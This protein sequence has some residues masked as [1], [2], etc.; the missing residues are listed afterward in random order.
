MV[1]LRGS[2]DNENPQEVN[3]ERRH[4]L[5][6]EV[7]FSK[8]DAGLK[9]IPEFN[10]KNWEDF[11]R[12]LETQFTI[13]GLDTFLEYEPSEDSNIQIRNDKLASAQIC[14]RL[15]H[16]QYKQVASCRTTTQIW[17]RLQEIYDESAE[18]KAS[19]IF[20]QFIHIQKKPTQSM[21][22]YLDKVVE[23][24]HDLRTYDI[25]L[26]E[27]AVCVKALDGLPET[28]K[29]I[30][31][32]A[33]ASQVTTIPR[34]TNLLLSSE[35]D[36]R[37]P[38]T[39]QVN[40]REQEMSNEIKS[41][42]TE[43]KKFKKKTF[44]E[45]CKRTNHSVDQCWI[46]HPELKK[47][48][49]RG[50]AHHNEETK[51]EEF[52][53]FHT[54]SNRQRCENQMIVDSGAN[55]SMTKDKEILTDYKRF[56]IPSKVTASNGENL[57]V[58]GKGTLVLSTIPPIKIRDVLHVPDLMKTLISTN[59]ITD[60]GYKIIIKKDL[61]ILSESDKI[62]LTARNLNGLYYLTP[63]A[64]G[65]S[66]T[67]KS[68]VNL[69][70]A[71]KRFGHA[72]DERLKKL[73]DN[74][75]GIELEMTERRAC[76]GC[77]IGQARR[78]PF[79]E[80]RRTKP[81]RPFEIVSSDIK[82]PL[83][84]TSEGY[85]YYI[86]YNC[87]YSKWCWVTFL[88][89]KSPEEVKESMQRFFT[90]SKAETK[91]RLNTLLTDNGGEY[92]NKN[93]SEFLLIKGIKHQR[94][95]PYSP[96]QNGAAE[97]RNL[98]IMNMARTIL[99][100][101]GLKPEF[102][103]FAVRYAV[104]TQNR[105]PTKAINWKT[106][107]EL[108]A[109]TKP[110]V[111]HMR[112]FGCVAYSHV[113]SSLRTSLDPTAERGIFLG[114]S[115][116]SKGYIFMR[117]NDKKV[118][119]RRDMTFDES[120]VPR[121]RI[122]DDTNDQDP[123]ATSDEQYS[124]Y[125]TTTTDIPTRFQ[126]IKNSTESEKWKK[127]AEEEMKAHDENATWSLVNIPKNCKPIHGKWV[128]TKNK[129]QGTETY[130]ARFV[131]KGFTQ[132]HGVNYSETY[133]SVLTYTS[134]RII[135][136]IAATQKWPLYQR[137]FRTAYLNA[138]L[139][140]PIFMHQPEG[141][142]KQGQEHKVCMLNKA[143][144]GLK[145]AGR[146][147]QETLFRTFKENS[148]Q[149]SSHEPCIWFHKSEEMLTIMGVYVDDLILTGNDDKKMKEI[150]TILH[151]N[152]RIKDLGTVKKFLGIEFIHHENKIFMT[153][154][155]YIK[156][157]LEKFKQ[158]DCKPEPTPAIDQETTDDGCDKYSYPI[159]E[160]LGALMFLA[161]VT[162]PD[163]SYA[164]NKL[165]RHVSKPTRQ[166]W[167]QVQRVLKYLRGTAHFGLMFGGSRNEV[168]IY[169]D[170]SFADDIEDRKSTT[171][172][173]SMIGEDIISWRS[174]KQKSVALSTTESEYMACCDAAK[175][176]IWTKNLLEEMLET[177]LKPVKIFQD[178][179]STIFLA[180]NNVSKRRTKHIDLRYHFV[181]ERIQEKA[182]ELAY[183]ETGSMVA[184]ILTK[185]LRTNLFRLHRNRI[186]F[187]VPEGAARV[188]IE[189][190]YWTDDAPTQQ[191]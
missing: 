190:A 91:Q 67:S 153:Q 171:G 147:W 69:E 58:V 134:L 50:R 100:D 127:A 128:F 41:L 93:I 142:V 155:T 7:N 10:G 183:C 53:G 56:Q 99:I 174:T 145:Q 43:L 132:K 126:D 185:P 98:T 20:L 33:R 143:L 6:Q 148:L 184:D 55:V 74:C 124:T 19:E 75:E 122:S 52:T 80:E 15:S 73:S 176:A 87:L 157:T 81:T 92:V 191:A 108:W 28:Y 146:S 59:S 77:A 3:E 44:C 95:V 49:T 164:V 104:Y 14:M 48:R 17:S 60:Q 51:D 123:M 62:V 110:D 169:A 70:N 1:N 167:R 37:R 154:E 68:S 39:N 118:L 165:S 182:I 96:E 129:K 16:S 102:W 141:F 22:S 187:P 117:E 150:D 178:N 144:Y 168:Y 166:L 27:L 156:E 131:A 125:H 26:G 47:S 152:Y 45:K 151:K 162:R 136:S 140:E 180:N 89:T 85:Q 83:L 9:L 109:G 13:M 175:E 54:E 139:M 159:R 121:Q 163:I 40:S 114:Y 106:P 181:R 64:Q 42:N 18:S 21:K 25:D 160:A 189:G 173:I 97:R 172:W 188:D 135:I 88:K 29:Q 8:Y 11:K 94:T 113:N 130:K 30:K 2:D 31:A 38:S 4:S 137:D 133:S 79:P 23:L 12:K 103:I 179:Q 120:T 90:D 57:K 32:A 107:H 84:A 105:L 5:R 138:H 158:I 63:Q 24:S 119:V 72:C 161:N 101:A 46:A 36:E 149:Q 86:T 186:V 82:G 71:H 61:Y 177:K 111:R 78:Q 35:R 116:Y 115:Q 112:T 66:T 34:L 76:E 65:N 170:S